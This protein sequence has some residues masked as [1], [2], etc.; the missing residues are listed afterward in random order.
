MNIPLLAL[1]AS[2]ANSEPNPPAWPPTVRVFSPGDD[3]LTNSTLSTLYQK[4]RGDL[5]A[6]HRT[7]LFF[8]PGSYNIDVPVGYYTT[9]HGLGALPSDVSFSGARGVH[10]S[11]PGR[12]LIQFWRS[13][14][15][16]ENRP[17][18]GVTEW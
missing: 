11:E 5:Y 1:L 4:T 7:A 13:V 9:V 3:A 18:S 2:S 16:V 12:N 14:E 8:K 6:S 17:R 15:N 10:Q